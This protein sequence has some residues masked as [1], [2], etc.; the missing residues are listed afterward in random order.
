MTARNDATVASGPSRSIERI[1]SAKIVERLAVLD[2]SCRRAASR[3]PSSSP[4]GGGCAR[5]RARRRLVLDVEDRPERAVLLLEAA[6]EER[7]EILRLDESRSVLG[8]R[9]LLEAFALVVV[10]LVHDARREAVADA[11]EHAR[12]SS[13]ALRP[14]RAGSRA[15][16]TT[17]SMSWPWGSAASLSRICCSSERTCSG[18]S[19]RIKR[20]GDVHLAAGRPRRPC[21]ST[22][23]RRRTLRSIASRASRSCTPTDP[24][25]N[26]GGASPRRRDE[27][28]RRSTKT[29]GQRSVTRATKRMTGPLRAVRMRRRRLR[30]SRSARRTAC[31]WSRSID[32]DERRD[33]G[34]DRDPDEEHADE[35][36]HAELAEAAEPRDRR[37]SRT[38]CSRRSRRRARRGRRSRRP[39]GAPRPAPSRARGTRGNAREGRSG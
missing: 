34:N 6:P 5:R 8:R 16:S 14:C 27:Q 15:R 30:R 31:S 9:H 33:D 35:A 21:C 11:L 28:R 26:A 2:A 36:D 29:S 12:A 39:R 17:S 23:R 20:A 38:R 19:A 37:A 1:I 3:C 25:G 24:A 7:R 22:R 10:E 32:D 13:S 18:V 4:S